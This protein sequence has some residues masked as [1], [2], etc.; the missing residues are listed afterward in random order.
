MNLYMEAKAAKTQAQ[1]SAAPETTEGQKNQGLLIQPGQIDSFLNE[2]KQKK[3]ERQQNKVSKSKESVLDTQVTQSDDQNGDGQDESQF[4]S[5]VG[6]FDPGNSG[7]D[8]NIEIAHSARF[9]NADHGANRMGQFYNYETSGSVKGKFNGRGRTQDNNTWQTSQ[10][11]GY[12]KYGYEGERGVSTREFDDTG[13]QQF[14]DFY[15][16][17][18]VY[19][20]HSSSAEPSQ[21]YGR[22]NEYENCRQFGSASVSGN[23]PPQSQNKTE[24]GRQRNTQDKEYGNTEEMSSQL[25]EE[26]DDDEEEENDASFC[27][28]C[29]LSF[30]SAMVSTV[31]A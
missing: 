3:L 27:K 28:Y 17:R 22:D 1:T 21:T 5:E 9:E 12:D 13:E 11:Y 24:N 19:G 29:Q 8:D 15:G 25:E 20:T 18:E 7:Y 16:T 10:N 14:G 26:E 30:K 23:Q 31:K 2:K 6:Q 4:D